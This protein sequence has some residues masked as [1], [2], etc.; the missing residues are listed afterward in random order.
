MRDVHIFEKQIKSYN[1]KLKYNKMNLN[2]SQHYPY[3]DI[4]L[5]KLFIV[6][7]YHTHIHLYKS[8]DEGLYT[9]WYT[10]KEKGQRWVGGSNESYTVPDKIQGTARFRVFWT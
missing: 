5:Y 4:C 10:Y 9:D 3:T 1:F 7:Y 8:V 6:C 2:K